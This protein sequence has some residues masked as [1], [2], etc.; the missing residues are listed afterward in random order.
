MILTGKKI[1]S[2]CNLIFGLCK[3]EFAMTAPHSCKYRSL[4][5]V[6]FYLMLLVREGKL[7]VI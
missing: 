6:M 7:L 3:M 4:V 2:L 1:V 5:F